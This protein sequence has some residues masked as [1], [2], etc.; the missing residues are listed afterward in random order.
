MSRPRPRPGVA[1]TGF[2]LI[3]L[4]IVV[5]II[6]ILASIAIPAFVKYVSQSKTT[7][8]APNLK[9]IADGAAS[10]YTAEHYNAAGLPLPERQ[11]PTTT[12]AFADTTASSVPTAITPGTKHPTVPADWNTNPWI[13]LKF[14]MIKPHYYRYRYHSAN[15]G[16]AGEDRFSA[17]A[18]GD[19]DSDAVFSRFN[20]NGFANKDGEVLVTGVFLTNNA[21]ELE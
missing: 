11:F 14:Q 18:E 8:V 7:E 1:A 6:G 10:Y 19:L 5:A 21:D 2:T 4:M 3:E 13:G 12:G 16:N 20:L 9:A 17:R 15:T